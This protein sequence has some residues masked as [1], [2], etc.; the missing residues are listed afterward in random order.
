MAQQ[1]EQPLFDFDNSYARLPEGFSVRLKPTSVRD[2][3][4]I[5]LN[6]PLAEELG[7][8]PERLSSP[9]G[10]D[11]FSGNAVALGSEPL[12]T[13]YAGHQFGNWVP[14]L[15]DGRAHLLGEVIDRRGV[16][17]DIQL[18]GSGPTPFSR[19]GDGRAWLGPVLREY[20]VSEAMHALGV[21]T[22]R[23]LAAVET[24]EQI[25]REA[26][27]PGAILTRV[28]RGL[29]RVGTFQY[30]AGRRDLAAIK[31]LADYTI[32]RL[33][34]EARE[35]DNPYLAFLESVVA[36]Q[37]ELIATWMGLG[38]IH[39]VMN[40]DNMSVAGE[41]IDYGPC[42]FMDSFHPNQVFSSIDE[43]GRYAFS[44]QPRVAQWNL[45][46]LAQCLLPLFAEDDDQAVEMAQAAVDALSPLYLKHYDENMRRKLGLP[47][48]NRELVESLFAI[49][50]EQNA[51]YSRTFR[52]LSTDMG[53]AARQEF[54]DPAALDE[55][56][57]SWQSQALPLRN[58]Q[59]LMLSANPALIP[60]NHRI[61]EAIQTA[62]DGDLSRFHDLNCALANPYEEQ[63]EFAHLA[64]GPKPAEIVRHTFCGT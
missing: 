40:T 29:I 25:Y 17:R 38:F 41:T 58:R 3:K 51:D 28:S 57:S 37:A 21:P 56:L 64:E 1:S 35:A 9:D 13:A 49:M 23:A 10:V 32:D 20:I 31:T 7:L 18:K 19:M 30:F 15:G 22:T 2:P 47:T 46:C 62:L 52:A 34:P 60:R 11:V 24:G 42:A 33:Y 45:V 8:D 54:D 39:G 27:L 6:M 53:L 14:Q 63:A 44:N 5:A 36:V 4:L 61:E 16:R 26:V 43:A 50:A 48:P 59:A 12:A 55:W